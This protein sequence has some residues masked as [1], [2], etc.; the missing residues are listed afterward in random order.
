MMGAVTGVELCGV[1][2]WWE[3]GSDSPPATFRLNPAGAYAQLAAV[4]TSQ[5]RN[6]LEE[7]R[8]K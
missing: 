4:N 7:N 5:A 1:S 2:G 3:N 8:L 6:R